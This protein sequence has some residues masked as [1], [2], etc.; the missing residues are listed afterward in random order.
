MIELQA[1][2]GQRHLRVPANKERAI[3]WVVVERPWIDRRGRGFYRVAIDVDGEVTWPTWRKCYCATVEL[4]SPSRYPIRTLDVDAVD[5]VIQ[6]H[7][8][9]GTCGRTFHFHQHCLMHER[10]CGRVVP[11][12]KTFLKGDHRRKALTVLP[13]VKVA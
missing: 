4:L 12:W 6:P 10:V 1:A 9:C 5:G 2:S 8:Q 11:T 13:W 7:C 3:L